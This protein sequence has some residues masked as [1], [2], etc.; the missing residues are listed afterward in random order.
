MYMCSSKHVP[1]QESL[2]GEKQ[3][4]CLCGCCLSLLLMFV[5]A[6]R[7]MNCGKMLYWAHVEAFQFP[8][9]HL[10]LLSFKAPCGAPQGSAGKGTAPQGTAG[11]GAQPRGA[12]KGSAG[13][14][15][16]PFQRVPQTPR[17]FC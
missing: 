5:L 10:Q 12:P 1:M 14:G 15:A 11:K 7:P 4:G 9:A 8:C 13:K 2:Y 6:N 3:D 16:Q 17:T